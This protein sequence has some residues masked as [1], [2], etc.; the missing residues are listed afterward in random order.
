[1]LAATFHAPSAPV[2]LWFESL[3]CQMLNKSLAPRAAGC[4]LSLL[5]TP[6]SGISGA[7]RTQHLSKWLT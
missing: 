5:S 3:H 4:L 2:K 7:E 6:C 1:M